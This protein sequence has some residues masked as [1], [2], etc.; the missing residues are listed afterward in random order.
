MSG[1]VL[2]HSK[3]DTHVWGGVLFSQTSMEESV[4]ILNSKS[5][6]HQ[7]VILDSHHSFPIFW[8]MRNEN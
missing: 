8:V 7:K 3:S 2:S 6:K 1:E 4:I 5:E